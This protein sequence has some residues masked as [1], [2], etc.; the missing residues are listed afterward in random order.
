MKRAMIKLLTLVICL[1]GL[2]WHSVEFPRGQQGPV[3]VE[4][5]YDLV[6]AF[7]PET[8]GY[9]PE[10]YAQAKIE[11]LR[12]S[13][14]KISFRINGFPMFVEWIGKPGRLLK[15]NNRIF[16]KKDFASEKAFRQAF[17]AKFGI[18]KHSLNSFVHS[19]SF[20]NIDE[21]L[22]DDATGAVAVE[23]EDEE[24]DEDEVNRVGFEFEGVGGSEGFNAYVNSPNAFTDDA[25]LGQTQ[26]GREFEARMA[27]TTGDS[28]MSMVKYAALFQGGLMCGMTGG[29]NC[30]PGF[31]M[32][33][34]L[35]GTTPS[36][37]P[38][39]H[40]TMNN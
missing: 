25:I 36:S 11:S 3:S 38:M 32:M 15:F 5:G 23:E 1:H 4:T 7:S 27:L 2:A 17:F 40:R 9:V 34:N 28:L 18:Q 13:P 19:R 10:E 14:H 33:N 35:G 21:D 39:P 26:A 37:I 29:T 6:A 22:F 16:I 31:G 20:A 24:E 8:A 12:V 30:T